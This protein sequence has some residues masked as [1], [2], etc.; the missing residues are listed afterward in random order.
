MVIV[1]DFNYYN[2]LWGGDN[3]SQ[4]R[5]GKANNIINLIDK[6]ALR[7]LLPR[8]TKTQHRGEFKSTINLVLAL[9]AL[10]INI[11]KCIPI[12]IDYRLDYQVI[13]TIF[14]AYLPKQIQQE[15][16]GLKNAPWKEINIRITKDL[17]R[18]PIEGTVQQNTDWLIFIVLKAVWTLMLKAKPSLFTKRQ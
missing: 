16:F 1:G 9:E 3:I 7:S 10:A 17:E 8:G 15:R 4:V 5:Q 18:L 12:K 14:K 6:I 13:E 2:Q 11:I